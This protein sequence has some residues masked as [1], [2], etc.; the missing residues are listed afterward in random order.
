MLL[1]VSFE[2]LCL[3]VEMTFSS[4]TLVLKSVISDTVSDS[5]SMQFTLNHGSP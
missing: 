4:D 3:P 5:E 2:L 1:D